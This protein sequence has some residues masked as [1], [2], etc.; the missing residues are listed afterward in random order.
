MT[1]LDR[2][3]RKTMRGAPGGE[4][5]RFFSPL[6]AHNPLKTLDSDEKFQEN[7]R[8]LKRSSAFHRTPSMFHKGF[9]KFGRIWRYLTDGR[10]DLSAIAPVPALTASNVKTNVPGAYAR[11]FAGLSSRPQRKGEG[12]TSGGVRP[13]P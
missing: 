2:R 1:G 8:D 5:T 7:P 11:R 12:L 6:K 3:G 10:D 4:A 13:F 9:P